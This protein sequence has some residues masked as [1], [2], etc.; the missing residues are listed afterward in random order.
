MEAERASADAKPLFHM[1]KFAAVPPRV[2]SKRNVDDP[3]MSASMERAAAA[4]AGEDGEPA[5]PTRA[6]LRAGQAQAVLRSKSLKAKQVRSAVDAETVA[7]MN[8]ARIRASRKAPVPK[9]DEAPPPRAPRKAQDFVSQNARE[10]IGKRPPAG[11]AP[12][13]S[14]TAR[15]DFGRIPDYLIQRKIAR[16][17]QEL[18]ELANAP[19]PDCPPGMQL[20]PEHERQATVR[21]LGANREAVLVQINKMPLSCDTF[22]LKRKKGLLEAQLKEIEDAIKIFSRPKVFIDLAQ[23]GDAEAQ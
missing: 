17:K 8:R 19:D 9:R 21:L 15:P 22:G 20:M 2:Q 6:F 13:A 12:A 23:P 7:E 1:K 4:E 11:P 16:A 10:T 18:E 14:A 3:A 5:P